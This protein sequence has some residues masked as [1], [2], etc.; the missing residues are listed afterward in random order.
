MPPAPL[1]LAPSV[2][3]IL[4]TQSDILRARNP[5][6]APVCVGL[7]ATVKGRNGKGGS[8]PTGVAELRKRGY[9]SVTEKLDFLQDERGLFDGVQQLPD[10]VLQHQRD[11]QAGGEAGLWA[12]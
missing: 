10:W 5:E 9:R 8:L 6:N 12:Q 7:V 4:A 2:S 11:Q 1:S 3:R